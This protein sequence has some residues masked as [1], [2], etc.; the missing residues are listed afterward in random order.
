[1]FRSVVNTLRKGLP[2]EVELSSGVLDCDFDS[3]LK[4]SLF[5]YLTYYNLYFEPCIIRT[6][7]MIYSKGIFFASRGF[8]EKLVIK[9]VTSWL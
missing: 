3:G 2:K 9:L 6:T 4:T 7:A 1:M 5:L 8:Y